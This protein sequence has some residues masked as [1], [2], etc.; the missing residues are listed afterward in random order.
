MFLGKKNKYSGVIVDRNLLTKN[1]TV[2]P[3]YTVQMEVSVQSSFCSTMIPMVD[4]L[5][6]TR[7]KG[8]GGGLP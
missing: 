3:M 7:G 4:N 5:K 6:V 2:F 1:K 8:R